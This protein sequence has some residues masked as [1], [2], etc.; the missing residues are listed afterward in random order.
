MQIKVPQNMEGKI[1]SAKKERQQKILELIT[2]GSITRQEEL[3]AA[4]QEVGISTTQ[5]TLS[6]DIKELGIAKAPDGEGGF[7]YQIPGIPIGSERMSLQGDGLLRRELQDFVIGVEA[8]AHTLILKTITGHAQGVCEAIDQAEWAEVAGTLAG[9]NT[10]FIICR[11]SEACQDLEKSIWLQ[12]RTWSTNQSVSGV[13]INSVSN[14]NPSIARKEGVLVIRSQALQ[15]LGNTL[16]Q[17]REARLKG[18][19]EKSGL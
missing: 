12:M 16:K 18:L 6:K 9:E 19:A 1:M 8:V 7:R 13:G 3:N 5:S 10:I 4:L 2:E 11:S 14:E 15:P 17:S